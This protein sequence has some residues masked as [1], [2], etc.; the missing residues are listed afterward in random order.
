ME[1]D[2]QN[3]KVELIQWLTTIDDKSIIQKIIDLRV[4][5]TEDWWDTISDTERTSI[6]QGIIDADSGKLSSHSEARKV[7]E[8]WL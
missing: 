1:A 3:I 5:Q 8:K 4:S 6:E 2:I 7:Y